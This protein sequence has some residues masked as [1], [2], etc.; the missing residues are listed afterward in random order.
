MASD[1]IPRQAVAAHPRRLPTKLGPAALPVAA[2]P[3][4]RR[5]TLLLFAAVPVL[6]LGGC[7]FGGD[8]DDDEGGDEGD[9]GDE[10]D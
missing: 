1:D 4:G 3:E 9:E 8:G 5:S 10:D 2:R 6:L 7:D